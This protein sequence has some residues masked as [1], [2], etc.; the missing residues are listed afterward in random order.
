[1]NVVARVSALSKLM[2]ELE[3]AS[4]QCL[5]LTVGPGFD[6]PFRPYGGKFVRKFLRESKLYGESGGCIAA[7]VTSLVLHDPSVEVGSGTSIECAIGTAENVNPQ[8]SHN[9]VPPNL[10]HG[11]TPLA[12]T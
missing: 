1:M 2:Q 6:L 11:S 9:S 5:F 4:N 12:M 8:S 3:V 7:E 10:V